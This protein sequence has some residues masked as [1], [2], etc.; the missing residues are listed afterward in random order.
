MKTY[1][2][3]LF[4]ALTLISCGKDRTPTPEPEN[5]VP[6][7]HTSSG[8][9]LQSV[10][11]S[12]KLLL[13]MSMNSESDAS[14]RYSVRA[15]SINPNID[16]G[17]VTYNDIPLNKSNMSPITYHLADSMMETGKTWK[18]YGYGLVDAVNLPD[19]LTFP[20]L[21]TFPDTLESS[22]PYT[23]SFTTS[24]SQGSF[25][26]IDIPPAGVS[27][28]DIRKTVTG[29]DHFTITLTQ[30]QQNALGDSV[31]IY[32]SAYRYIDKAANLYYSKESIWA[33][34]VKVTE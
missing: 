31:Y 20:E 14:Y 13:E 3:I 22:Q 9:D 5:T 24:A 33:K 12:G 16:L 26:E 7:S 34:W 28:L 23:V 6:E 1:I 15:Q 32:V 2:P 10:M 8:T 18:I 27:G 17:Q 29:N 21:N 4:A 11:P 19:M 30:K 25:I